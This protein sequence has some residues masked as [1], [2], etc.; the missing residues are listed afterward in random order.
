M[1]DTDPATIASIT[2]AD[3][4]IDAKLASDKVA[5]AFGLTSRDSFSVDLTKFD[6]I[7]NKVY[8]EEGETAPTVAANL[9]TVTQGVATFIANL[10]VSGANEKGGSADALAAS[11]KTIISNLKNVVKDKATSGTAFKFDDQ[12]DIL[13][14]LGSD[15]SASSPTLEKLKTSFDSFDPADPDATVATGNFGAD[16]LLEKQLLSQSEFGD[17]ILTTAEAANGASLVV[18]PT[19]TAQ[20]VT[21]TVKITNDDANISIF[22]QVDFANA[23]YA[24]VALSAAD[25]TK[26]GGGTISVEVKDAANLT[27]STWTTSSRVE[28]TTTSQAKHIFTKDITPVLN[29]GSK[30]F[31]TVSNEQVKINKGDTSS[32]EVNGTLEIDLGAATL[33]TGVKLKNLV[34]GLDTVTDDTA[35]LLSLKSLMTADPS[36][37][38]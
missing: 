19:D 2:N 12:N 21:A 37:F 32:L 16:K 14:A 27:S 15:F 35:G 34:G 4:E 24:S 36:P 33:P 28:F 31:K 17:G 8:V 13:S 30:I 3:G 20:T 38:W 26:L 11:T 29:F 10:V 22:K 7:E 1:Q 6:P 9:A 5:K 25:L 18:G 23:K